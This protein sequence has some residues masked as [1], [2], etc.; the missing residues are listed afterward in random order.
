MTGKLTVTLLAF[1]F[2]KKARFLSISAHFGWIAKS[3]SRRSYILVFMHFFPPLSAKKRL[4]QLFNLCAKFINGNFFFSRKTGSFIET[5]HITEF[6]NYNYTLLN[7]T[8]HKQRQKKKKTKQKP[9]LHITEQ[10]ST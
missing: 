9:Q 2:L 5:K 7:N 10:H 1:K 3:G 8:A 4:P 6:T